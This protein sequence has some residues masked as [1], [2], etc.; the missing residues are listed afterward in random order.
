MHTGCIVTLLIIGRT[1]RATR[2]FCMRDA[3]IWIGFRW[4]WL[5]GESS[6]CAFTLSVLVFRITFLWFVDVLVFKYFCCIRSRY[7]QDTTD[8][9]GDGGDHDNDISIC[10]FQVKRLLSSWCCWFFCSSCNSLYI[11][12]QLIS[13]TCCFHLHT[14]TNFFNFRF[15]LLFDLFF[16]GYLFFK[17]KSTFFSAHKN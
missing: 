3:L 10:D 6:A 17:E 5:Y 14:Q 8:D 11:F 15:W 16:F 7:I 13:I 2:I 1:R 4:R 12:L 9:D